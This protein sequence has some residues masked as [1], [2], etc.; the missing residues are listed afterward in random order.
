MQELTSLDENTYEFT[1]GGSS[2]EWTFKNS[3]GKFLKDSSNK[4]SFVDEVANKWKIN[5]DSSTY[6]A[7]IENANVSG[8]RI[9]FNFGANPKRF[10]TYASSTSISS[11]MLLPELYKKVTTARTLESISVVENTPTKRSY[12]VDEYFDPTGLAITLNY[13]GGKTKTVYYDNETSNQFS[14]D[15]STKLQITDETWKISYGGKETSVNIDV[16]SDTLAFGNDLLSTLEIGE[17]STYSVSTHTTQGSSHAVIYSIANEKDAEGN[18]TTGVLQLNNSSTGNVTA[19]KVGSA[20]VVASCGH[21]P[22]AKFTITV[23]DTKIAKISADN[24]DMVYGNTST[25]I[26]YFFLDS[27]DKAFTPT[28]TGVT[29]EVDEETPNIITVDENG[30][31]TTVG[32]GSAN[33]T[34][35]SNTREITAENVIKKTIV[36]T[37]T[38]H[39]LQFNDNLED[40]L[41]IGEKTSTAWSYTHQ[42][43]N[44]DVT[45]NVTWSS[46]NTDVATVSQ[47]GNVTAVNPTEVITETRTAN[48]KIVCGN[49]GVATH[50]VTVVPTKISKIESANLS[51]PLSVGT[52]I[53]TAQR[54]ISLTF[55]KGQEGSYETYTPKHPE[56][57]YTVDEQHQD[58]ISV[59]DKGVVTTLKEG[60]AQVTITSVYNTSV[61]KT[62]TVTVGGHIPVL[63]SDAQTSKWND[64]VE[65]Q[66]ISDV[67]G[68]D[69]APLNVK[70][71]DDES[72]VTHEISASD[73]LEAFIGD[74]A[75]SC[76][77]AFDMDTVITNEDDGK[78]LKFTYTENGVSVSTTP[79]KLNVTYIHL[80]ETLSLKKGQSY[81]FA[82]DST[83][84]NV[85]KEN[86]EWKAQIGGKTYNDR[87]TIANGLVNV[88]S[89]PNGKVTETV[90]VTASYG[91]CVKTCTLTISY[92][93]IGESG[94]EIN[95]TELE[96]SKDDK[97]INLLEAHVTTAN[98]YDVILW[99]SSDTSVATVNQ[100]SG[101]ITPNSNLAED[102]VC[103]IN[104]WVDENCNGLKDDEEA[105]KQATCT[106][107]VVVGVIN[108]TDFD[109]NQ[110]SYKKFSSDIDPETGDSIT[111][112]PVF[113]PANA[114]DDLK[115]L[116]WKSDNTKVATVNSTASKTK[117]VNITGTEG[118]AYISATTNNVDE[119]GDRLPDEEQITKKFKIE[120]VHNDVCLIT[121]NTDEVQ[122]Y[123]VVG[124]EFNSDGLTIDALF[125]DN[126]EKLGIAPTSVTAPDMS[127]SGEKEVVV[128]Y[129][130]G[131]TVTDSYIIQVDE[132]MGIDVSNQKTTFSAGE[133]FSFNGLVEKVWVFKDTTE[134]DNVTS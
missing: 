100:T 79:R 122:K 55:Y 83:F 127:T 98:A 53:P 120:V 81:D 109:F 10:K 78:Y 13:T 107:S 94:I 123:F 1:L 125:S 5:I 68:T 110:E 32:E 106:L 121:S 114:S 45:D 75:D 102:S 71:S 113:T 17:S 27:E 116:S 4:L 73:N 76:T 44:V 126:S 74:D 7:T 99:D 85:S 91:A 117:Q 59:S 9:L 36:V 54:T 22:D 132:L 30:N 69:S 87:V 29:F 34:I 89:L 66:K 14:I 6:A 108:V 61:S 42:Y 52:N 115:K 23:I 86:I 63:F 131:A 64:Y 24:I 129:T 70:F 48:I 80:P 51:I 18:D 112:E 2:D 43:K 12:A 58:V 50:T 82:S 16:K 111:L 101:L 21:G 26:N 49:G 72:G 11:T 8:T 97:N 57:T 19:L 95:K 134:E 60:T 28:N 118:I 3:S 62:I 40:V 128:S 133:K 105:A 92:E 35:Y 103:Y 67:I 119:N 33:V 88:L 96:V 56:V 46:D 65:G 104:A 47:T 37:V 25:K 41:E 124:D 130:D 93:A 15:T 31:I 20:D 77:T 90:I 39:I 38:K 84:S